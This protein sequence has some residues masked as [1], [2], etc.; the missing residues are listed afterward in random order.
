MSY[1]LLSIND[2]F[3]QISVGTVLH[4]DEDDVDVFRDP[5]YSHDVRMPYCGVVCGFLTNKLVRVGIVVVPKQALDSVTLL[6]TLALTVLCRK[7]DDAKGTDGNDVLQL[8]A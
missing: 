1:E 8:E 5:E 7:E 2:S 4:D 6:G 3:E